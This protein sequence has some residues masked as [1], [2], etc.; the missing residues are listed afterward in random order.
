MACSPQPSTSTVV[1]ASDDLLAEIYRTRHQ[2]YAL[3]I[4]QHPAN[5]NGRLTDDLDEVNSFLALTRGGVLAGFV[6]VTPPG[7]HGYSIDKYFARADLPVSVDGRSY[8]VRPLIVL[9][10]FRPSTRI[11]RSAS[12]CRKPTCRTMGRLPANW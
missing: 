12:R 7:D 9:P 11:W 2:V 10:E 3:E 1:E 6:S 4:G 5:P 8:G